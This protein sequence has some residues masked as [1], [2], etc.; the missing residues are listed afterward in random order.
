MSKIF[1][2]TTPIYYVNAEPHIGHAYTTIIGDFLARWHRLD[3]YDTHYLTGTDEHGEK[4]YQAAQAASIAPQ[5]FVDQ[6]SERFAQAWE[7]LGI[8]HDDFIRTT[9]ERHT[10]VVH[11][12]LQKVHDRGDIYYDEY[13]GL[14]CV[15]CERFLTEKE[16]VEGKCPTH[17]TV[18]EARRE[19]NYFFRMEQYRAWLTEH[20]QTHP[21]FIQPEGYRNEILS[22]LRESIGDLSIS[23]PKT[24]VPWGIALPW[25]ESHVTYVWFDALLNYVSALGYP[26]GERFAKYWPHTWHLIGKDILKTHA[27]FWPTMLKSA[28]IPLYQ[29]LIVGG[30]LLGP[31]GRKMSK[32]LGNVVDPFALSEKYGRDA[33]RYFLLR[34]LP[35]GQDGAVGEKGLVERYNADL[36]NDLGN[37]LARV[38]ALLLRHLD[39]VIPQQD[40]GEAEAPISAAGQGLLEKLRPLVHNLRLY[41]AIEEVL[42][43]VR[44][45][46]RYFNDQQPWK[47]AKDPA[48]RER[49]GT[50]LYQ[51]VE[52]L[53]ITSVLLE[54]AIPDKARQLRQS[55]GLADYTL[56][57]AAHWGLTPAGTRIP[58]EA[59]ILFPK[60]EAEAPAAAA[61][62][63]PAL[64]TKPLLTIDDFAKVDL[65]VAVVKAAEKVPKADK[66]LKLTLDLGGHERTVVSGI[67]QWYKPEDLPGRKVVVVANLQ[68]VKLRGILSEGMILAAVDDQGNLTLVGLD[69]DLAS[70]AEV[71]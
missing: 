68:P 2:A 5:D 15:G 42:Q 28:G 25:D 59:P 35:Y 70:G 65:R 27:V 71:R 24:R 31:D 47:L 13:E 54:S 3:G 37:L 64:P 57:Q 6:I 48:Q 20:I 32:S 43:F 39:G 14:Y 38:R 18:P 69:Q 29:R 9:Q 50:V 8:S 7:V 36:A 10:S 53:R 11:Q 12:V 55:L 44:S 4:I 49:L 63:A 60:S 41:A 1:Y 16:L 51:V 58:A 22:M 67:A 19:G 56:E 46:N 17:H 40:P 62:P 21:D 23:R 52:G 61:P 45:L 26:A 34:E 33:L 30:Y 66:L